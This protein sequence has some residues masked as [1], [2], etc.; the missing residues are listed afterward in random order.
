M[1]AWRP[2]GGGPHQ[3]RRDGGRFHPLPQGR[4]DAVQPRLRSPSLMKMRRVAW[5]A[6][7]PPH[8]EVQM[9]VTETGTRARQPD[10]SGYATSGDG[11]RLYYE[12]FGTGTKTI[13]LMPANP[14]S[15]SRLWKAQVHYLARHF[16]VVA[17]NGRG[18]GK[19][20]HPDPAAKW[21]GRWHADDC[22]A[23]MD[24]TGTKA[25]VLVGECS[26]GVYPSVQLAVS[27]PDRVLGI[28]AIA[29]GVPLLTPPHAFRLPARE[30]FDQVL[31]SNEGWFKYNRDY[32][33]RNYRGFLEFF[34]GELFPEP[35]S[36]KQLEDAVAYGLDGRGETMRIH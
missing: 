15:H 26:D 12:V 14:I 28:V 23:V 29:P 33:K 35:H 2:G 19:S 13:V 6:R 4:R 30:A 20:D 25:A 34:F 21:L 10:S 7:L 36:S 16:R 11:L 5:A 1:S 27:D 3:R 17:Y 8:C 24:A 32:M 18:N 22:L 9:S 31:E